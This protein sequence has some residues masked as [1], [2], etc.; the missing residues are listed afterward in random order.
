MFN[1]VCPVLGLWDAARKG[2]SPILPSRSFHLNSWI[3]QY[4]LFLSDWKSNIAVAILSMQIFSIISQHF[5]LKSFNYGLY[6]HI[7][8]CVHSWVQCSHFCFKKPIFGRGEGFCKEKYVTPAPREPLILEPSPQAKMAMTCLKLSTLRVSHVTWK[9]VFV[10]VIQLLSHVWLFV[11][12][13][14]AACQALLSSTISWSLPKLMSIA[15]VMPANHLILSSPSPPALSLSQ[16]QGLFQWVSSVLASGGQSIGASTLASVLPVNTCFGFSQ[17]R[18]HFEKYPSYL[19]TGC[20]RIRSR[21]WPQI[22]PLETLQT[23]N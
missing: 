9:T 18:I 14:T 15:S 20:S 1:T 19:M 13:W 10:V 6:P 17:M 7:T 23:E 5:L 8:I 12:P 11:A 3:I 2:T 22:I 16:H 4:S 21:F